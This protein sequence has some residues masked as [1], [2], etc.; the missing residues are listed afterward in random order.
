M[1]LGFRVKLGFGF[2]PKQCNDLAVLISCS[3]AVTMRLCMVS[4]GT[5]YM[6][7]V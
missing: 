1:V 5:L 6:V 2:H 3:V 4:E 7:I